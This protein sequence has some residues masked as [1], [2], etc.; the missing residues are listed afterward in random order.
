[1]DEKF[2][3]H[4][5]HFDALILLI[6][7]IRNDKRLPDSLR[8]DIDKTLEK[9]TSIK[10]DEDITNVKVMVEKIF[11]ENICLID[12]KNDEE[13]NPEDYRGQ[14]V[15]IYYNNELG[16]EWLYSV[17][18]LNS[19]FWIDSFGTELEALIFCEK[20]GLILCE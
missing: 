17:Q 4:S 7:A 2:K 20:Y 8:N 6:Y 9:I 10:T 14:K 12:N 15:T 18:L 1:M 11:G 19:D 3:I 13:I 16:T 5:A